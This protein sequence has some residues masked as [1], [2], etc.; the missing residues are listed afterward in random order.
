[1]AV[2]GDQ[3]RT[4]F[5]ASRTLYLNFDEVKATRSDILGIFA[6]TRDGS[7]SALMGTALLPQFFD[8][9]LIDVRATPLKARIDRALCGNS[10]GGISQP[11]ADPLEATGHTLK[12]LQHALEHL[13][14]DGIGLN[15]FVDACAPRPLPLGGK[16]DFSAKHLGQ[17]VPGADGVFLLVPYS[18][19]IGDAR[20]VPVL[21]V[22]ADTGSSVFRT[23]ID[24]V[25][26]GL[27]VHFRPGPDHRDHNTVEHLFT[28]AS[29]QE[30]RKKL[31]FMCGP[32][33]RGP[34]RSKK[35]GSPPASNTSPTTS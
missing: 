17:L 5:E 34:F 18:P 15:W 7:Q 11:K 2:V 25:H 23:Y 26:A 21:A 29:L 32:L 24:M 1:M 8:D 3:F 22:V 6:A 10:G 30:H 35:P 14:P 16:W 33:M 9:L 12:G 31:T 4:C 28:M 13:L 20:G 19:Y 27:Y